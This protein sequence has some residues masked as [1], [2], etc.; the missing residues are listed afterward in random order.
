MNT[1]STPTLEAVDQE[2]LVRPWVVARP[3]EHGLPTNRRE[4]Q[5]LL[6]VHPRGIRVGERQIP[7]EKTGRTFTDSGKL[8]CG[9]YVRD[10]SR[11]YLAR[12][13][14]GGFFTLHRF[15]FRFGADLAKALTPPTKPENH[16]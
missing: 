7:R 8:W 13:N 6:R 5:K 1:L 9:D 11:L 3:W 15:I 14:W 16:K 2:R 12:Y 10:G 4:Q